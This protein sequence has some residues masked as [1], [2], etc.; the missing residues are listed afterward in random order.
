MTA[1][2]VVT[3]LAMT[4]VKGLRIHE[5]DAL[6]LTESGAAG[7]RVFLLTD[8]RAHLVNGKHAGVLNQL[9]AV[10]PPPH[11][12][13][14]IRF[15][16]GRTVADEVRL[17]EPHTM[18]AYGRPR[19]V[20]MVL[21]PWEDALSSFAGRALRLVHAVRAGDGVDRHRRG[22]VTLISDESLAALADAAEVGVVD[23]RRFRMTVRVRG[24]RAF[25]EDALV[26][27]TLRIGDARVRF[28]GNVG[29]CAVTTLHPEQGN[30]D[31]QTLQVLRTL[32]EGVATTEP[33]PFGVWGEVVRPGL[34]RV[35]DSVSTG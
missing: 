5:V 11:T 14:S 12:T 16:D 20:R 22:G 27:Q 31:L 35:G 23:G 18:L 15:P 25:G 1:D 34:V 10:S 13:L 17:G 3:A 28:H 26:D 33:L 19:A 6:E 24:M 21:G 8:E 2:A 29:R 9:V 30:A 7:D 4:P 32:R